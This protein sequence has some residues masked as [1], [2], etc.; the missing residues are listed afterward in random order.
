MDW[1][2]L[3]NFLWPLTNEINQIDTLSPGKTLLNVSVWYE[4]FY[5]FVDKSE[6]WLYDF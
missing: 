2:D 6:V 3:N 4:G 1:D 5:T